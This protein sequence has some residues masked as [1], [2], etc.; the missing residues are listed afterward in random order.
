MVED[1]LI[2][3]IEQNT[4]RSKN[5]ENEIKKLNDADNTILELI[6]SILE[7]IS[8]VVD[9]LHERKD[10][11]VGTDLGKLT[12]KINEKGGGKGE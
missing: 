8:E 7:K 1:I 9:I 12:K 11:D 5:N 6:K 2:E 4:I 3:L 10:S